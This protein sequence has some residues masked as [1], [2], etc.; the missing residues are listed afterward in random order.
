MSKQVET[1]AQATVLAEA[2]NVSAQ[3]GQKHRWLDGFR[4][5][6][7]ELKQLLVEQSGVCRE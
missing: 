3:A 4:A 1:V 6:V 2:A 7:A 5:E